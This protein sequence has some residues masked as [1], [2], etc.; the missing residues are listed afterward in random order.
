MIDGQVAR[1]AGDLREVAEAEN[2]KT[3]PGSQHRIEI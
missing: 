1:E 2:E 3:P